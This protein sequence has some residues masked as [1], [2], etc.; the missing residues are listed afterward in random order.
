MSKDQIFLNNI[1]KSIKGIKIQG[2]A[3]HV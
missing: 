1:N 3:I 2:S